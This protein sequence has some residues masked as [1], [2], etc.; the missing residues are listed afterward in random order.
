MR[1]FFVLALGRS[2]THFFSKLLATDRRGVVHHEPDRLDPLLLSL[3]HGGG[4][5]KVVEQMLE[6][7]FERLLPDEAGVEF[8]GETNSYLRYEAEWL[9]RRFSPTLVHVVRDGRNYV[10]SAWTRP[11]FT[12]DQ[13]ASII[14]PRDDDPYAE[15]WSGM[16]RF[17][18]LCWYW[19]HTNAHLGDRVDTFV[20]FEDALRDY[21]A[22]ASGV[23]EPCGVDVPR[24]VWQREVGRPKNTSS[25]FRSRMRI[26]NLVKPRH[27]RFTPPEPLPRW[28]E[29]ETQQRERFW[30]ICGDTMQ[31]FGYEP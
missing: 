6:R 18:K 5:G 16:S 13:T 15:R 11:V 21:D 2:G 28:P 30:E 20:R 14:V 4:H 25:D 26:R 12:D 24:E 27:R 7:R 10:R 29:W 3:R 1:Y 22:F 31:R 19:Q 8:Y 9:R 17:E 23:L